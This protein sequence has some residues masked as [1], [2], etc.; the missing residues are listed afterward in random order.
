MAGCVRSVGMNDRLAGAACLM[1]Y[2][3]GKALGDAHVP[4]HCRH[5]CYN[6]T[7]NVSGRCPECGK[8]VTIAP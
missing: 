4:G 3:L 1:T 5:C 8:E 6:L 2:I 7:G